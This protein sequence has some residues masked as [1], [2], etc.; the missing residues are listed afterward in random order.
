MRAR[1]VLPLVAAL[2]GVC[3]VAVAQEG[4]EPAAI[5]L[6]VNKSGFGHVHVM[7]ADGSE[8][9]RITPSAPRGT[10]AFG[11]SS[12]DWSPNGR[13]IAFSSTGPAT[14]ETNRDAEIYTSGPA[15]EQR[16]RLT[17][18][19]V[20][21]GDPAFSP[22]GRLIAFAR[23]R[24]EGPDAQSRIYVMRSDGTGVRKLTKVR[25]FDAQPV[26]SPD[27]QRIAFTRASADRTRGEIHVINADGTG[28]TR[29]VEDAYD[30]AWSPDGASIA[31]T[32]VR[33]AFGRTCFHE[34][35]PAEEVYVADASGAN[36]RRLTTLEADDSSPA[37]TVDGKL[38]FVSDRAN[39]DEHHYDVYAMNA[40]GSCP[41]RLTKNGEVW[42]L[43]P[44][45]NP[46]V[47]GG[48]S[49]RC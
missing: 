24:G 20:A 28:T 13:R 46:A 12:P 11:N 21:D 29:I 22:D 41:T 23:S 39:A 1:H 7:R 44:D 34:C 31:F 33:D 48:P 40:D 8:R 27:G 30:P 2:A 35:S 37:W 14:R 5:V 47:P 26:W 25:G 4:D 17:R 38:L 18:N 15:G 3:A 42:D 36:Q 6:T 32:T 45:W 19:S 16:R 43:E 10:D 9:K 49:L